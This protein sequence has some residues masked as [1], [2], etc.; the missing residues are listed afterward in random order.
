MAVVFVIGICSF[1]INGFN[2]DIDFVGGTEITYD[3]NKTITKDDEA[4]IENAVI[5]AIGAENFSSLKI[6]GEN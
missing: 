6:S 5:G 2:V 1:F 3:I 4:A